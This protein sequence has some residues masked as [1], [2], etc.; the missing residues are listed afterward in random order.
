MLLVCILFGGEIDKVVAVLKAEK[1]S[2]GECIALGLACKASF[3]G[4]RSMGKNQ[5][6]EQTIG[7]VN[8]V[9]VWSKD[10]VVFMTMTPGVRKVQYLISALCFTD[11][12]GYKQDIPGQS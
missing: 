1:R 10:G 3:G 4:V 8:V 11:R 9:K 2:D 7:R 5:T 6:R 12:T